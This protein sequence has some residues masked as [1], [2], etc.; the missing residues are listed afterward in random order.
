MD[1]SRQAESQKIWMT[2]LAVLGLAGYIIFLFWN[3]FFFVYEY[4]I[5]SFF[6]LLWFIG[7]I[8]IT[9]NQEWGRKLIVVMSFFICFYLMFSLTVANRSTLSL[10]LIIVVL[11]MYYI[12]PKTKTEFLEG[13]GGVMAGKA[14]KKILVIDDDKALLKMIRTNLINYGMDVITA[15]TGEKGLELAQKK[16]PDL[17]ILDVILPGMKGREVCSRLKK[18]NTTKEIPIM[19]LTA[20]DSPDDIKAEMAAGAV[21]HLTKPVNSQE[22][23]TEIKKIL[24]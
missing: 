5:V 14:S 24:G 22:L 10:I 19:F 2:L 23:I 13:K 7:T 15:D 18:F 20:K 11:M 21:M 16:S 6:L 12:L 3:D 17:I 8:G 4:P 1:S 9:R